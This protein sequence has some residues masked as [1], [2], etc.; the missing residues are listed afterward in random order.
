MMGRQARASVRVMRLWKPHDPGRSCLRFPIRHH[1]TNQT[2]S[3]NDR[4]LTP[5][6]SR[7]VRVAPVA[8]C[9]IRKRH[10]RMASLPVLRSKALHVK[11]S[12][13]IPCGSNEDVRLRFGHLQPLDRNC[14]AKWYASRLLLPVA[15]HL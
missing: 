3:H 8:D 6:L 10:G 12:H 1:V 13:P 9:L 5:Q 14:E 11:G 15:V 2:D 4:A 7:G